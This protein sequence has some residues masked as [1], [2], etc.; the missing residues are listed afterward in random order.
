MTDDRETRAREMIR[1]LLPLLKQLFSKERSRQFFNAGMEDN[2]DFLIDEASKGNEDALAIMRR[3]VLAA[4][5]DGADLPDGYLAFILDYFVE[6]LPKARSGP[7]PWDTIMR[8]VM[9]VVLVQ[10]VHETFKIPVH[11]APEHRD[12]K[13]GPFS[14]CALVAQEMGLGESTVQDIYRLG[15][16]PAI[17]AILAA[18][19]GASGLL[20]TS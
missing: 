20:A 16:S 1:G 4:Q 3:R 2:V 12:S 8:D 6:G 11:R 18:D 13:T 7:K 17:Q 14:A 10:C 9:V 5:L 19:E 15:N